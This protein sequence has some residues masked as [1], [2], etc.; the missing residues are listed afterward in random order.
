MKTTYTNHSRDLV[1]ALQV[2]NNLGLV[3]GLYAGEQTSSSTSS[4]LLR[5]GQ[6]VEFAARVR[7]VSGIFILSEHTNTSVK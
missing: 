4:A 3:S 1:H 7:F 6:V 5:D 2:L